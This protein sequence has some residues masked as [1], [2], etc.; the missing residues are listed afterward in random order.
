MGFRHL[1]RVENNL[2]EASII[3]QVDEDKAA[4]IAPSVHP[5]GQRYFLAYVL[6][7]QFATGM[8]L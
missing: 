7:P 4:V 1:G 8:R 2:D 6:F 3:A 5:A